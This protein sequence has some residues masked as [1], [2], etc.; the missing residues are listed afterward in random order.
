[1]AA[2]KKTTE[3]NVSTSSTTKNR[4][5]LFG[6]NVKVTKTNTRTDYGNKVV[7]RKTKNKEVSVSPKRT[8]VQEKNWD[9]YF[10]DKYPLRYSSRT[11]KNAKEY[12]KSKFGVEEAGS[13][14]RVIKEKNREKVTTYGGTKKNIFGKEKPGTKVERQSSLKRGSLNKQRVEKAKEVVGKTAQVLGAY[15]VGQRIENRLSN[16]KKQ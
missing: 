4:R 11:N 12:I 16:R 2:K 1:M 3:P 13:K 15:K 6:Q 10:V 8:V 5:N 9:D 14:D 7:D